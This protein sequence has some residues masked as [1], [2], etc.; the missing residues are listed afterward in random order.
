MVN[1]MFVQAD[2]EKS[3]LSITT[4]FSKI[5]EPLGA[6]D[7]A[8]HVM[9]QLAGSGV[10]LGEVLRDYAEQTLAQMS[11]LYDAAGRFGKGMADA[12]DIETLRSSHA[13]L[14]S[15]ATVLDMTP[16]AMARNS[17]QALGLKEKTSREEIVRI[18]RAYRQAPEVQVL[19]QSPEACEQVLKLVTPSASQPGKLPLLSTVLAPRPEVF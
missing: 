3:M 13:V 2:T 14:T 10:G 7:R 19:M 15:A 18:T 11:E 8:M 1:A 17:A 9:E 16:A 6:Y 4:C 12:D 5:A